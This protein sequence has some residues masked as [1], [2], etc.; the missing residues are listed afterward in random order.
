MKSFFLLFVS[1]IVTGAFAAVGS[2][3]GHFF[4]SHLGVMLGGIIGGIVGAICSARIAARLGWIAR[5]DFYPTT[6]GAEIGFLV[7]AVIAMKT[8]SSPIGPILSSFLIG[9]GALVGSWIGAR[10]RSGNLPV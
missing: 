10:K 6:F 7:A 3:V 4:G 8:L 5:E 1:T 2:M 9:V